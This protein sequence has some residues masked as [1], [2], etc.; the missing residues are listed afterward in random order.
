VVIPIAIPYGGINIRAAATG[1][2][3]FTD[4]VAFGAHSIAN[5]QNAL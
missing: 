2:E 3:D 4:G 1:S 5:E